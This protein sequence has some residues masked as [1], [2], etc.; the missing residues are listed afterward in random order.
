MWVKTP[1]TLLLPALIIEKTSQIADR[2]KIHM[3]FGLG[4]HAFSKHSS[5]RRYTASASCILP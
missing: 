4:P 3:C 5:A 1:Y 2:A